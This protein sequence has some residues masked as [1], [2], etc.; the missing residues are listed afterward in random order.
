[1]THSGAIST[2]GDHSIGLY[3]QSVGGSGGSGGGAYSGSAFI[4]VAIAGNGAAG[5]SGGDVTVELLD[6]QSEGAD[7][8]SVTTQGDHAIGI[9]AQSIG[10]GGGNGGDSVQA[11]AGAFFS[12]S[13]SLA[14]D[15]GSGSD[16]GIVELTGASSVSTHGDHATG[17][18]L[19][20]IGGSGGNG[21]TSVSAAASGGAG[22][23]VSASV[24]IG[25]SGSEAGDGN[26]VHGSL[27]GDVTTSGDSSMGFVAQ[28]VGGGG[29]NG[30]TTVS[31]T[32][33][34]SDGAAM[35]VSVGVGGAGGG[36]GAGK[37]VD[38]T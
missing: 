38:L 13:V 28:S 18:L 14:G 11:T 1:V 32:L 27:T 16:A 10:G 36:G 2:A 6:A 21:G 31:G 12:A 29:G 17:V 22:G 23:S 34:V 24:S 37:V 26:K 15:G 4:G 3:A 7:A 30:G 35:G 5:A 8:N 20:S 33:A 25:G 19:E 9:L